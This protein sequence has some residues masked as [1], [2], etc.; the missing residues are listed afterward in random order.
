MTLEALEA[1]YSKHILC[2]FSAGAKA[3]LLP[4]GSLFVIVAHGNQAVC[5]SG[6]WPW[7]PRGAICFS[8]TLLHTYSLQPVRAIYYFLFVLLFWGGYF[9][10]GGE[11]I[12]RLFVFFN[13]GTGD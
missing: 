10:G 12:I 13:G 1:N 9:F 6:G 2:V 3:A 7:G 11:E 5:K 8:Q 4:L